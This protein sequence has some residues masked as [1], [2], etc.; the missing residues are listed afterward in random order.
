MPEDEAIG[1]VFVVALRRSNAKA[2]ADL[3]RS[4]H[5]GGVILMGGSVPTSEVRALTSAVQPVGDERGVPVLIG[6]DEEGGTVSR[7]RGIL[8]AHAGL[9]G[10]RRARRRRR[11]ACR[12]EHRGAAMR[13]MGITVDFAPVADVTVGLKDPTI[14]TRSASS[15]PERASRSVLAVSDG[16]RDGGVVPVIKHF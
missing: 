16:S 1:A 15:N 6:A 13:E 14:R 4:R 9:H 11:S 8:P 2:A 3:V 5:L 12:V 10:G 7:L